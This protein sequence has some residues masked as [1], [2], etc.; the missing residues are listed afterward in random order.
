MATTLTAATLT[1]TISEQINL[2]SQPVN[3]ENKLTIASVTQIDKRIVS[4]PTG[5]EVTVL[6]FGAAVAAGQLI[7]AN[8]K[9]VR[10]TNKDATNFVRVRVTKSGAETF[11]VKV[12]AG[13]SFIMGNTKESVSA[14]AGSFSAFVDATSI[15]AQADTAAVD[16]E[17]FAASI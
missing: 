3:S 15:S 2:N 12:E 9:Y 7:A 17:I 5:S 4:I 10:I 6:N 16:V 11:D 1:V 8:T 13:K 14:T